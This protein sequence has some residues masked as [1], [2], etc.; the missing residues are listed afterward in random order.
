MAAISPA[1]RLYAAGGVRGWA[2]VETL[3]RLGVA[4]ALV[5]SAI[6][7]GALHDGALHDGAL[8]EGVLHDGALR[9]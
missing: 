3:R 4:G 6:H 2:D 8:R 7:D 5:A 9:G 1:T